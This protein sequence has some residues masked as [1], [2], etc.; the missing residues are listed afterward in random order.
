MT[1]SSS[2]SRVPTRWYRA[3]DETQLYLPVSNTPGRVV[4][5]SAY[6]FAITPAWRNRSNLSAFSRVVRAP[7]TAFSASAAK[8]SYRFA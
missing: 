2:P 8:A 4:W 5:P 3:A 7:A 6:P 1:F